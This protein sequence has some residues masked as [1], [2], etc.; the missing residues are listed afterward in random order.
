M[1]ALVPSTVGFQPLIV[2]SSVANRN[3][4][5]AELFSFRILNLKKY[6]TIVGLPSRYRW[7]W[8]SNNQ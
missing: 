7:R 6:M 1:I 3:R 4:A 2:P 8:E 5:G